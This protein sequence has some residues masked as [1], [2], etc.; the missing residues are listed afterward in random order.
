MEF[1][2]FYRDIVRSRRSRHLGNNAKNNLRK[3]ESS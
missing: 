2:T 1:L 3:R